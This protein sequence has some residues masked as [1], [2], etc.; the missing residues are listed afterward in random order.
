MIQEGSWMLKKRERRHTV[1]LELVSRL[2]PL[3][4]SN[5]RQCR[6]RRVVSVSVFFGHLA[7]VSFLL[8]SADAA[9]VL[10]GAPT[11][12]F[13]DDLC[14]LSFEFVRWYLLPFGMTIALLACVSVQLLAATSLGLDTGGIGT[15]RTW[16]LGL[17]MTVVF[18]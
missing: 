9:L 14:D 7:F 15:G 4:D 8:R 13:Q 2:G 18:V 11:R 1:C 3:A 5:H 17:H 10:I 16:R 6:H 12:C